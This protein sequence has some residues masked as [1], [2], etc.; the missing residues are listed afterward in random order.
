MRRVDLQLLTIRF[1]EFLRGAGLNARRD[2]STEVVPDKKRHER[3]A[4]PT[5]FLIAIRPR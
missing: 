3:L 2:Q 4:E 5:A 1:E